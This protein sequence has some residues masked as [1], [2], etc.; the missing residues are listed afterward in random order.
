MRLRVPKDHFLLMEYPVAI[1]I[2]IAP[3]LLSSSTPFVP[4]L[5]LPPPS[6]VEI[7]NLMCFISHRFERKT[8]SSNFVN[9]ITSWGRN[10]IH[11]L[12]NNMH[13]TS[14]LHSGMLLKTVTVCSFKTSVTIWLHGATSD[15]IVTNMI[16]ARQ[17]LAKHVP[18][19]Y[20]VN[21]NRRPLLDNGFR[22]H[23]TA[24][25]SDA[26]TV[27]EPLRAVISIRFFRSY[28]RRV[29]GRKN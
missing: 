4:S 9:T 17:R 27:L 13:I 23:G 8:T 14:L 29:I 25:V 5:Y 7:M 12:S 22:Y 11:A 28:R 21:K 19:R 18:E 2:E 26:T 24:R 3:F 15:N 1:L 6:S 10:N 16:V 20:A